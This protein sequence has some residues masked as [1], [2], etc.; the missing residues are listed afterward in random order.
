MM[1]HL[2]DIGKGDENTRNSVKYAARNG[3]YGWYLRFL[4]AV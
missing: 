2:L 1:L 4:F 3:L